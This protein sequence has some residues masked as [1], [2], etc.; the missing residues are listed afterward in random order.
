VFEWQVK[1]GW[2]KVKDECQCGRP[3]R[4]RTK[5]QEE[6]R[7]LALVSLSLRSLGQQIHPTLHGEGPLIART[8]D[9]DPLVDFG[10]REKIFFVR[11][12]S[13]PRSNYE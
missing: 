9:V 7:W 6:R 12:I 13:F 3:K 1:N 11:I 2:G 5:E 10:K 4:H 8:A